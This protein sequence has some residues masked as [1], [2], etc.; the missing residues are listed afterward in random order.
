MLEKIFDMG[1]SSRVETQ[2]TVDFRKQFV[3]GEEMEDKF[4]E[5]IRDTRFEGYRE[6][7]NAALKLMAECRKSA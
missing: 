1:D 6:G 4:Y 3:K 2:S 5:A 7:M